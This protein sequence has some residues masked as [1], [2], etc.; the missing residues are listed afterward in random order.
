MAKF[1]EL[2]WLREIRGDKISMIFQN[3]L[4]SLKSHITRGEIRLQ[5]YCGNIKISEISRQWKKP[6]NYVKLWGLP[7]REN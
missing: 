4:T 2:Q 3:P 6:E 1:S 7:K 5:W